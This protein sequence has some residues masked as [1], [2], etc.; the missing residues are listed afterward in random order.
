MIEVVPKAT[1]FLL[2]IHAMKTLGACIDLE[3]NQCYLEKLGRSLQLRQGRN[4]LYLVNLQEL[5]LPDEEKTHDSFHVNSTAT[6]AS[7]VS[8]SHDSCSTKVFLRIMPSQREVTEALKATAQSVVE[9]LKFLLVIL[10]SQLE[11]VDPERAVLDDQAQAIQRLNNEVMSQRNRIEEIAHLLRQPAVRIQPVHC[12]HLRRQVRACGFGR[13]SYGRNIPTNE[14]SGNSDIT[15]GRTDPSYGE[16]FSSGTIESGKLSSADLNNTN[17]GGSSSNNDAGNPTG[18]YCPSSGV[19]G[20]QA[21]LMGKEACFLKKFHEVYESDPGTSSGSVQGQVLSLQ[22]DSGDVR[23]SDV[24]PK[25][26]REWNE[27]STSESAR[28]SA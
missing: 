28:P 16:S 15:K 2:S 9:S 18:S 22:P 4:G 27:A 3:N 10:M 1:P 26:E 19:M 14:D 23:L 24:L 17:S 6:A 21:Y 8:S 25:P 11:A 5:C 7:R 20:Q 13:T 12:S